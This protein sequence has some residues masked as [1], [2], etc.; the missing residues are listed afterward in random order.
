MKLVTLTM[1]DGRQLQVNPEH[2]AAVEGSDKANAVRLLLGSGV[3][4]ELRQEPDIRPVSFILQDRH[5]DRDQI[6]R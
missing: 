3:F 5:L 2:V 6:G 1:K 4:Y